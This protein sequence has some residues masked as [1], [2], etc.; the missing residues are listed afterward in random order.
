MYYLY[1]YIVR[2][3]PCVLVDDLMREFSITSSVLGMVASSAY[4]PYV[5]MQI[6][7]GIITDKLGVKVM[8]ACG[9]ALCALGVFIFG[10]AKSVFFLQVGRFLIGLASASAFLCCGKVAAEY[11]SKDKYALLMGLAMCMGCIGGISGTAPTAFLVERCGWRGA[12]Y[13]LAAV[14]AVL[15]LMALFF[16]KKREKSPAE[17]GSRPQLL[18]G[19]KILSKQPK[20]WLAGL[21]GAIMYLPLSALAE[22][23]IVPYTGVRFGVDTETASLSSIL[24]FIGFAVGSAVSPWVAD[25]INSYKKTLIGSSV[26]CVSTSAAALYVGALGFGGS[27]AML[28]LSGTAAGASTLVFA[29]SYHMAPHEYSGSSAG[30]TNA[31]IMSSGI[32]FQP[33]LGY[34]IDF[35]K[36]SDVRD[37][38]GAAVSGYYSV[39]VYQETFMVLI[40]VF[41][42]ALIMTFFINEIKARK[43][44]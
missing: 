33:I 4:I 32:I 1:T 21:Y 25:K 5:A 2:V 39:D 37:A 43:E 23:W 34:L 18:K 30:F 19:I 3:E 16:I 24:L 12:T 44:K 35:Y 20:L 31:L 13:I 22:L 11:F 27:L 41:V 42:A 40:Y 36:Q 15:T 9:C 10:A 8:V 26:L 29:I 14:G 38:T 6:P 7:C 17:S 28:F